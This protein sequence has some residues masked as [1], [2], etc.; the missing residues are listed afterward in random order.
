MGPESVGHYGEEKC[1]LPLPKIE[2]RIPVCLTRSLVPRLSLRLIACGV[3]HLTLCSSVV[4]SS[5]TQWVHL[6]RQILW[7]SQYDFLQWGRDVPMRLK[8]LG[9]DFF[10]SLSQRQRPVSVTFLLYFKVTC[11]KQSRQPSA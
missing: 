3:T 4:A 7:N 9:D 11:V 5:A 6:K 2:L 10:V 1:V 8:K